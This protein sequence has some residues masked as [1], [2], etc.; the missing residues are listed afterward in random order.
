[1]YMP[2][3]F[4][5]IPSTWRGELDPRDYI[6]PCWDPAEHLR[7]VTYLKN[8]YSLGFMSPT[9]A[10]WCPFGCQYP[11]PSGGELL[12]DGLWEFPEILIHYVQ[13]HAVKPPEEFLTHVRSIGFQVPD[14]WSERKLVKWTARWW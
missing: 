14:L 6:D 4:D 5:P 8:C 12:T 1:M 9:A 11:S 10:V 7:V 3:R 2:F 13:E